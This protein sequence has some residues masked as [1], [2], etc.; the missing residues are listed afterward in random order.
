[1]IGSAPRSTVEQYFIFI[2]IFLLA[3]TAVL[4]AFHRARD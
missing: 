3:K 1:M 4:N 2:D